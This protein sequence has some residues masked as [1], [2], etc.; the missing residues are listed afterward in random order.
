MILWSKPVAMTWQMTEI[1]SGAGHVS[2][3]FRDAGFSVCSYDVTCDKKHMDFTGEAGF[4]LGSKTTIIG[5]VEDV[6]HV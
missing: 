2:Q 3:A 6:A 5:L 4:A 1:F